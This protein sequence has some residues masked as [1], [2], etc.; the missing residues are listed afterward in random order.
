MRQIDSRFN[1]PAALVGAAFIYAMFGVFIRVM[2]HM[3]GNYA[4]VA[5]RFTLA[6]IFVII[7]L[8]LRNKKISFP[9]DKIKNAVALGLTFPILVLLMTFAI[10][11]TTIANT[12][13]LLYAGS[14]ISAFL[15]GTFVLKEKLNYIKIIAIALA[16]IGLAFYS[17]SILKISSGIFLGLTA[18]LLDGV[19]NTLRKTLGGIDRMSVLSFQYGVASIVLIILT[20]I[21]SEP[22]I[23]KF[24]IGSTVMT[25]VYAIVLILLANLL[26]YGFHHSDLNIGTVVLSSELI[27]AAAIGY[28]FYK[29]I[30]QPHEILGGIFIFMASI[31]SGL[32]LKAA[33]SE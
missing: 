32:S 8:S 1:G 6:T 28:I 12:T 18:G 21:S 14:I 31:L 25:F 33:N 11:R 19:S 10:Q 22:I 4:Q 30:P 2:A 27:F 3:W 24:D 29:E 13:F 16:L 7:F 15:I 23:K 5:A 9:R 26:L 20:L 17:S